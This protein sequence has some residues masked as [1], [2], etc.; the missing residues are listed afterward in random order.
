MIGSNRIC[1]IQSVNMSTV[2]FVKGRK[3]IL[4]EK[5]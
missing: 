2:I 5:E 4:Y 3:G 1:P